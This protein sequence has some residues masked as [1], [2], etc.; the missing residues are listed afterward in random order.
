MHREYQHSNI[1][2][3]LDDL[4]RC[5]DSIL[6]GHREIHD[7]D[8]GLE[9]HRIGDGVGSVAHLGDDSNVG[10]GAEQR[11]EPGADNDVVVR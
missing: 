10:F 1:R 6:T 4:L 7:H 5:R 9:P 11:F 2:C 8:V 3:F